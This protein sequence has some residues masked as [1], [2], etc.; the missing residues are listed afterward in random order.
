MGRKKGKRQSDPSR[1]EAESTDSGEEQQQQQHTAC[2][3]VGRAVQLNSIKKSLK[4]A[5]VRVGQCTAC[6]K[7]SQTRSG[8][9][10]KRVKTEVLRRELGGKLTLQEIKKQQLERA[11]EEQKKA[12][13]ALKT[14]REVKPAAGE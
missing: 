2:P 6:F 3:H 1:D 7:E 9:V 11:K 10:Q 13:E 5:W 12:A 14:L 8:P 4:F